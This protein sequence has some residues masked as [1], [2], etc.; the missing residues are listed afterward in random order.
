MG[1]ANIYHTLQVYG[2][3]RAMY[4]AMFTAIFFKT[5]VRAIRVYFFANISM[6]TRARDFKFAG[7][8]IHSSSNV[9]GSG[10]LNS[11]IFSAHAW[12]SRGRSHIHARA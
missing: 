11:E 8:I 12:F 1:G 5:S 4:V 3:P 7:A 6:T 10:G 9:V 2:L